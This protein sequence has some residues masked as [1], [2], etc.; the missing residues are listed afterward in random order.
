MKASPSAHEPSGSQLRTEA[1]NTPLPSAPNNSPAR[2]CSHPPTGCVRQSASAWHIHGSHQPCPSLRQSLEALPPP[3]F[4]YAMPG[5][6]LRHKFL[7]FVPIEDRERYRLPASGTA[8]LHARAP[9]V[10]LHQRFSSIDPDPTSL[11]IQLP[12]DKTSHPS[13]PIRADTPRGRS[14]E[15]QAAC[16]PPVSSA[17]DLYTRPSPSACAAHSVSKSRQAHSSRTLWPSLRPALPAYRQ[18]NDWQA[19]SAHSP[20]MSN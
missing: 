3:Q 5:T 10:P 8:A 15:S 12:A 6:D 9:R 1:G 11:P 4:P 14:P 19:S 13:P 18:N 2:C 20:A 7:R 17:N 16:F